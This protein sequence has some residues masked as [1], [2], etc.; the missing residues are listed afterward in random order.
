MSIPLNQGLLSC[1]K[2]VWPLGDL[3]MYQKK[4]KTYKH[5]DN[6]KYRHQFH[7]LHSATLYTSGRLETS[8]MVY[9]S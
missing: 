2:I 6:Y 7:T 1:I 8:H 4:R 9:V 5:Q 3:H